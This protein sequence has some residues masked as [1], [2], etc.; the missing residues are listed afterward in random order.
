MATLPIS[1]GTGP[2]PTLPP[3]QQTLIPTVNIA[4]AQGWPPGATPRAA[5]GTRV[6]AF[7]SDL[8]HPRWLYVLPNGDVLVAETNA[9]PKPDDAQGIKGWLMG[10]FMK[11]AGAGVP[12]GTAAI[13]RV[14]RH[15]RQSALV[16][17]GMPP[18][19]NIPLYDNTNKGKVRINQE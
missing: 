2:Q 5:P 4:P 17:K 16:C 18:S 15:S 10:L 19:V 1:A 11:A 9:P 13:S 8:D 7:A 14:K 3:P 12:C 6:A